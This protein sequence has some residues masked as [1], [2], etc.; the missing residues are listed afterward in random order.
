MEVLLS[1][2]ISVF[3]FFAM[4]TLLVKTLHLWSD[5]TAEWHLANRARAVRARLMS[6][7][8]GPGSGFLSIDEIKSIKTNPQWCTM[9]YDVA[10]Q[11]EKYWIRGSIDNEAPADQSMFVKNNK[12][13]G[14]SWISVSGIKRGSHNRPDV[15]AMD[16]LMTL[17]NTTLHVEYILRCDVAGRTHELS[18]C[19][20]AYLVNR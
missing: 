2:S 19:I 5:G 14:Q 7:P 15:T 10:A 1:V 9:Q 11:N 12:G 8:M 16:C 18:Q 4:G 17:S 13:G 3:V 6:G 20:R